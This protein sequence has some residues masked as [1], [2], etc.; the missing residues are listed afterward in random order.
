VES[1]KR[2]ERAKEAKRGKR[3]RERERGGESVRARASEERE[4]NDEEAFLLSRVS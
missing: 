2:G 3:E 4:T 1:E